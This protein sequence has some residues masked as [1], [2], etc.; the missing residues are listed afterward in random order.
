MSV[1]FENSDETLFTGLK[2]SVFPSIS[3]SAQLNH[4]SLFIVQC[5][6]FLYN[7]EFMKLESMLSMKEN[8]SKYVIQD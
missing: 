2:K 1:S 6:S 7:E 5:L 3:A 8:L 4:Y